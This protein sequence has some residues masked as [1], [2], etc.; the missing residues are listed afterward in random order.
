MKIIFPHCIQ[1]DAMDCGPAC[2]RM[3]AKYYFSV[4]AGNIR[5]YVNLIEYILAVSQ[6]F[7]NRMSMDIRTNIIP[8]NWL[9][10]RT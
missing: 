3:I 2:L 1:L 7:H 5:V 10:A 8:N 6:Y 9:K 4:N